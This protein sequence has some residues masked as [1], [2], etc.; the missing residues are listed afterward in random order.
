MFKKFL[1]SSLS[2]LMA[3]GTFVP[4]LPAA[5]AEETEQT[6]AYAQLTLPTNDIEERHFVVEEEAAP[7]QEGG[8]EGEAESG[9]EL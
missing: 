9:S 5:A 3:L 1:A 8:S 7:A 2:V 6:A 4:S